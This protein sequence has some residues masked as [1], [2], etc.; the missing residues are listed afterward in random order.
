M[1]HGSVCHL[2]PVGING[3]LGIVFVTGFQEGCEVNRE[4]PEHLGDYLK[5]VLVDQFG[6]QYV[7]S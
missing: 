4:P 6:M 7:L 2:D 5:K 1:N 3:Q